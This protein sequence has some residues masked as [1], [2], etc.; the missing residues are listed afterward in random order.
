MA[1]DDDDM[2]ND[3]V[4][5]IEIECRIAQEHLE[6]PADHESTETK[7]DIEFDITL[8]W[9][10]KHH[11]PWLSEWET[12][13]YAFQLSLQFTKPKVIEWCENGVMSIEPRL[14]EGSTTK[15]YQMM[16]IHLSSLLNGSKTFSTKLEHKELL[17]VACLSIKITL[18]E[19]IM[20]E[21]WRQQLIP[22]DFE[23]CSIED[24]PI[25]K[26]CD[27]VEYKPL[28]ISYDLPGLND[29]VV[30]P[31]FTLDYKKIKHKTRAL[32]IQRVQTNFR[33]TYLLSTQLNDLYEFLSNIRYN[34]LTIHIHS[35]D[36]SDNTWLM[37]GQ[38]DFVLNDLF[39]SQCRMEQT[40][41]VYSVFQANHKHKIDIF[42]QHCTSLTI[43]YQ[44]L[45]S[46]QYLLELLDAQSPFIRCVYRIHSSDCL[47]S[48]IISHIKDANRTAL[49]GKQEASDE[50]KSL[51]DIITGFQI[52]Q[53]DER[54]V[55][56]EGQKEG[57]AMKQLFDKIPN[58]KNEKRYVLNDS[59]ICFEH[60]LYSQ[61]TTVKLKQS[62]QQTLNDITM[63]IRVAADEA[64][65]SINRLLQTLFDLV[66]CK[67]LQSARN[68]NLFPTSSQLKQI[69]T[70]Q[71]GDVVMDDEQI[72]HGEIVDTFEWI[73][74]SQPTQ[75]NVCNIIRKKK[76]N[77]AN[78]KSNKK[79]INFI[80]QHVLLHTSDAE[81]ANQKRNEKQKLL[82]ATADVLVNTEH[83]NKV[84]RMKKERKKLWMTSGGWNQYYKPR[85]PQQLIRHEPY[86]ECTADSDDHETSKR[87]KPFNQFTSIHSR[88][89]G[90]EGNDDYFTSVFASNE[91]EQILLDEQ[92]KQNEFKEWNQKVV[93]D[94]LR[95]AVD[96]RYKSDR[97]HLLDRC[98][99][100]C[101]LDHDAYDDN[102]NME[103]TLLRTQLDPKQYLCGEFDHISKSKVLRS[104]YDQ[105]SKTKS[106]NAFSSIT[107]EEI[108]KK[109]KLYRNAN[110]L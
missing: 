54:C 78:D 84:Q 22:F 40:Q 39:D 2:Q 52:I 51:L 45:A 101:L 46:A 81:I 6:S 26:D 69:E 109:T 34:T 70:E 104:S 18:N 75:S 86:D 103:T 82:D 38:C 9:N 94:H 61:F 106:A 12:P 71:Y 3:I 20:T 14:K 65:K 77:A 87:R 56:I 28:T 74:S 67:S 96:M 11:V 48:K 41:S 88:L 36:L 108:H 66:Q 13:K 17:F 33:K 59:N 1:S 15:A 60:R 83:R 43:K 23:I 5:N 80:L 63:D 21:E 110:A 8:P 105:L 85:Q 107:K 24:L 47:Y 7:K 16:K 95:F 42:R 99:A 72:N 68:R 55:V 89:F 93:V 91:D 31:S 25:P 79:A 64:K 30:S 58:Q 4:F 19:S 27:S 57:N 62:L 10:N 35:Q 73:P 100:L 50:E 76:P 49:Q 37:H 44:I 92:R 53:N 98:S 97:V 29:T 32:S 102:N 90:M